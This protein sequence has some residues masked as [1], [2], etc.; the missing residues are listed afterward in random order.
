MKLIMKNKLPL[1]AFMPLTLLS[2][3]L[4][5]P[6]CNN[7]S[8]STNN[9]S[10]Q[11]R[12][13]NLGEIYTDNNGMT[14]YTFNDDTPNT[15][16]CNGGCAAKWPPL[17]ASDK[18]EEK[19]RFSVITRAD[20]SK[21]WALDGRPLYR[22]IN[23]NAPGDTTGEEVRADWYVAQTAPV[24]KRRI[25]VITNGITNQTT[26]LTDVSG[27]TLY[28]FT[29][30]YGKEGGSNC[31]GGCAAKWPPVLANN[32]DKAN[33]SYSIVTRDDGSK[34]WAY[35]GMPLYNFVNDGAPGDAHGENVKNIWYVAQAVPVN[36][37]ST[38][39]QGVIQTDSK[40]GSL[41]VLDNETTS[42][43]LC[44]GGCLT[45][46][47]PL[48][49]EA[50]EINRADYTTFTNANNEQQW[51]Y[52]DQPLYRWKNDSAPGQI[53]G[54]GLAHPSGATWIVAKP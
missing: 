32:E 17:I 40:G 4:L 50:G 6:A 42:N 39:D 37:Y 44:K 52:K 14:L 27:K 5:L 26:V 53:N 54:Q 48:K 34:Q 20:N 29:N 49:A 10:V 2:A 36:K 16:N 1:N 47:P 24:S 33:G 19:D 12:D 18:A 46:W 45:A 13:T 21:Q 28:T 41:Y 23:D 38:V 8:S 30:D 31:N 3:V 43:L 35:H 9:I 15:S 25:D 11:K 51:A 22:W 7:G